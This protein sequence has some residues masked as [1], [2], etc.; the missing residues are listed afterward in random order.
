MC[1]RVCDIETRLRG[2]QVGLNCE[3]LRVQLTVSRRDRDFTRH[4]RQGMVAAY[5]KSGD[6][7]GQWLERFA[8]VRDII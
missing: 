7:G 8:V 6:R 1:A 3:I 5:V 4:T 2:T